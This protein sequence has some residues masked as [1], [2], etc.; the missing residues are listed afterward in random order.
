MDTTTPRWTTC[1]IV[2]GPEAGRTLMIPDN[3]DWWQTPRD[4]NHNNIY[5]RVYLSDGH[6]Q[7]PTTWF[8]TNEGQ[9]LSIIQ[10]PVPPPTHAAVLALVA[11]RI[12]TTYHIAYMRIDAI[13]ATPAITIHLTRPP[14]YKVNDDAAIAAIDLLARQNGWTIRTTITVV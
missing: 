5:R 10:R 8:I 3:A 1:T 2:N 6:R 11:A 13:T 7:E 9:P 4:S 12:H 14:N